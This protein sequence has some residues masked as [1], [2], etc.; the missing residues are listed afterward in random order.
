MDKH[1]G[2]VKYQR[3]I[4]IKKQPVRGKMALNLVS[5]GGAA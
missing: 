2:S 4:F 3:S 5:R 1:A